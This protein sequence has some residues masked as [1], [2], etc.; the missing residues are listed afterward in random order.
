MLD[1]RWEDAAAYD[2][3]MGRWSRQLA[4]RFLA[5]LEMKPGAHWL[6]IGCGTGSLT[7][8]I[9]EEARPQSVTAC[10]TAK[11]F[12]NYCA[13]NLLYANLRVVA[14][15]TGDLPAREGGYDAVVS[16]LVLNFL[17]DPIQALRQM[18]KACAPGGWVAACVWDYSEG[19]EFLRF[20]WDAAIALDPNAARLHEGS[21]FPIC[22]PDALRHAL[23]AADLEAVTV[24]P[25]TI[26]TVFTGFEEYWGSF[27]NSPG[28]APTY[29]S[30][31]SQ[32]ARQRLA[33]RLRAEVSSAPEGSIHLQARAWAVKGMNRR[34][35]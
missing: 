16:S 33:G 31:L 7:R 12:V 32:E 17:P 22:R 25:I 24:D 23:G 30:S 18:R 19:M 1:D 3:F 10:D 20:F 8:A 29:V 9:L 27:L 11:D 14:I 28:P 5:W 26:P 6:E 4:S 35:S 21:R 2:R 15:P 34:R 13:E